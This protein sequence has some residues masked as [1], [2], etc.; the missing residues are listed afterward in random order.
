M[1][2][3]FDE[4]YEQWVVEAADKPILAPPLKPDEEQAPQQTPQPEAPQDS[5]DNQQPAADTGKTVDSSSFVTLVRL[6]KD[7]YVIRPTDEDCSKI[8]DIGEINANNASEKF[9]VILSMIKKYL[10]ELDIDLGGI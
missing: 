7:A 4:V 10:P 2:R 5:I 6:L 9:K 8:I 3:K 1:K